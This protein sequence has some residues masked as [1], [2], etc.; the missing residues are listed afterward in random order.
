VIA[1]NTEMSTPETVIAVT[2]L[3][4]GAALSLY[5]TI[6]AWRSSP[7]TWRNLNQQSRPASWER[8]PVYRL[9]WR[10][11]DRHPS[12]YLWQTRILG[13]LSLAFCAATA[14][15]IVFNFFSGS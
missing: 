7:D 9:L 2:A 14:A 10:D 12:R 3:L 8:W 5:W 6:R 15:F 1:T 13:P 11:F 4:L